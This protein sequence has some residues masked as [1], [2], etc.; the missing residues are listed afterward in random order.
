MRAC[1]RAFV[2]VCMSAREFPVG[3][4]AWVYPEWKGT[5]PRRWGE[6]R[7]PTQTIVSDQV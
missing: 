5:P 3:V 2:H 6:K 7:E 1:V 4:P